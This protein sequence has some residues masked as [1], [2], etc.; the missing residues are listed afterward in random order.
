MRVSLVLLIPALV[1]NLAAAP[2]LQPLDEPATPAAEQEVAGE[3]PPVEQGPAEQSPPEE[4]PVA[5]GEREG[6]GSEQTLPEP[7]PAGGGLA[8]PSLPHDPALGQRL[9][10]QHCARCHGPGGEGDIGDRLIGLRLSLAEV[11]HLV[12]EPRAMMASF[13]P[14]QLSDEQVAAIY[15]YLRTLGAR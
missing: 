2:G 12:R 6:N 13:S 3:P 11:L 9:Y 14:A 7:A 1:L 15:A 5:D 10:G 8:S 4:A